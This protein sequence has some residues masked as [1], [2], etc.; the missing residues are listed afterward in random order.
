MHNIYKEFWHSIKWN[1]LESVLYHGLLLMHQLALYNITSHAI[2]GLI[3]ITF[4][5]IFLSRTIINVGLDASLGAFWNTITTSR[6]TFR[7]IIGYNII[8]NFIIAGMISVVAT[9]VV[10]YQLPTFNHLNIP[11][12]CIVLGIMLFESLKRTGKTIVQLQFLNHISALIET[13]GIIL[14]ICLVWNIYYINGSISLYTIFVPMFCISG[15]TLLFFMASIFSIYIQLPDKANTVSFSYRRI[16]KSRLF[17]YSNELSNIFFSGNFL[18]PFFALHTSL[19]HIGTLKLITHISHEITSILR[20][21]FGQ[22][23]YAIFAHTKNM[24]INIKKKAFSFI[25]HYMYQAVYVLLIFCIINYHKFAYAQALNSQ[26][27]MIA[28]IYFII[29]FSEN[30]FMAYEKLFITEEKSYYLLAINGLSFTGM[31]LILIYMPAS[32]I[33]ITLASVVIIRIISFA[34]LSIISFYIWH[35]KP[36]IEV[37]PTFGLSA[38]VFSLLFLFIW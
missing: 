16:I 25:T 11:L 5:Y 13:I 7:K 33:L 20:A 14:Y 17:N 1:G 3:G 4:S 37:R 6:T 18:I 27:L 32:N 19:A 34:L 10:I 9:L 28:T 23:S 12:L 26:G 31:Y 22:A 21:I 38:L 15:L 29:T 24:G 35:I 2:Y 30:F 36:S 8:L